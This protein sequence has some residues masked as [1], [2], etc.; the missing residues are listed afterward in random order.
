[1]RAPVSG[2]IKRQQGQA[3]ALPRQPAECRSGSSPVALA[4][5]DYSNKEGRRLRADYNNQR[6]QH[7]FTQ[8]AADGGARQ[9]LF[10]AD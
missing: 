9:R 3:T 4:C 7:A 10:E 5:A 2:P 6:L 1:M 8:Q